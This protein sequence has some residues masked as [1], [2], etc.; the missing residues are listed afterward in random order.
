MALQLLLQLADADARHVQLVPH[1]P[2]VRVTDRVV[3]A[4]VADDVLG[5]VHGAAE[6]QGLAHAL[7]V[8]KKFTYLRV[9]QQN[10]LQTALYT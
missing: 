6:R 5:L 10:S 8:Q 1:L 2:E 4:V 9:L 3:T 7:W